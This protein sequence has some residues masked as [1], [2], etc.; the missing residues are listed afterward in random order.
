M[1]MVLLFRKY[2]HIYSIEEK[3][4]SINFNIVLLYFTNL[5]KFIIITTCIHRT[6]VL[7][8]YVWLLIFKVNLVFN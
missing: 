4:F 7:N 8:I 2:K 6:I 1:T 5:A 3:V